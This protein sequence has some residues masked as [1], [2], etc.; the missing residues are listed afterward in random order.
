MPPYQTLAWIYFQLQ[1]QS[2][3]HLYCRNTEVQRRTLPS[4]HAKDQSISST[5]SG[6]QR[7]GVGGLNQCSSV[8]LDGCGDGAGSA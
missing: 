8:R 5:C 6:Y 4:Y 3:S 2:L 1:L 7:G